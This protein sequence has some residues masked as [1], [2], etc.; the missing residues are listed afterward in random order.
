L[1]AFG[2]PIIFVVMTERWHRRGA[3]RPWIHGL[4]AATLAVLFVGA[5]AIDAYGLHRC[6]HHD[7]LPGEAGVPGARAQ[8]DGHAAIHAGAAHN[9]DVA[10]PA[11]HGDPT[12]EEGHGE[13]GPCSC[14]GLC[15]A[16]SVALPGFAARAPVP[17][18]VTADAVSLRLAQSL[19][20]ARADYLLPFANAPPFAR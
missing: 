13:H 14:I 20:I 11:A 17:L 19:T 7:A 2:E 12:N 15:G 10:G 3:Q 5:G 1:P 18:Q 16:A 8:P 9:G 4:V 6:P